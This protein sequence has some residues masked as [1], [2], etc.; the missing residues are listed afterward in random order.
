ML[1]EDPRVERIGVSKAEQRV[2]LYSARNTVDGETDAKQARC[3][4]SPKVMMA[5]A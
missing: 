4:S 2:P 1:S 3:V 5:A